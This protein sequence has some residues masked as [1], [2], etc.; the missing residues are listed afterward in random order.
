MAFVY[1]ERYN[2]FDLRPKFICFEQIFI[3]FKDTLFE[4]NK[5]YLVQI[6]LLFE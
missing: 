6:N 4:P 5:F 1:G 3:W 2:L